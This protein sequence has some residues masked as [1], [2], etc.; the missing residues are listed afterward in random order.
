MNIY[1]VLI[2]VLVIIIIAVSYFSYGIGY[3][4]GRKDSTQI[5]GPSGGHNGM[6]GCRAPKYR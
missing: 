5:K 1:F 6:R 4:D 2:I 3:Q